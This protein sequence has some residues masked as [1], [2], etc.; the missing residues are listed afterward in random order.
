MAQNDRNLS[1]PRLEAGSL[2]SQGQRGLTPLDA[3]EEGLSFSVP[4][5]GSGRLS[6]TS[7]DLWTHCSSFCLSSHDFLHCVC[8]CVLIFLRTSVMGSRLTLMQQGLMLIT[9]AMTLL[10]PKIT[11]KPW[12]LGPQHTVF[13][14]ETDF[15]LQC[16]WMQ[17]Y[18]NGHTCRHT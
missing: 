3:S 9:S 11:V 16:T 17:T 2:S 6:F 14:T 8:L 18:I 7:F 13:G 12:W 4:A 10:P 1:P 15:S 5:A